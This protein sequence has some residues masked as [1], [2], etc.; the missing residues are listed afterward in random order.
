[1]R[2]TPSLQVLVCNVEM[3]AAVLLG[4]SLQSVSD[5]DVYTATLAP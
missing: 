1:M 4:R 3:P 2:L 5:I